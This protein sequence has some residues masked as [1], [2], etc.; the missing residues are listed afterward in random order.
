LVKL[1]GKKLKIK[2]HP[3]IKEYIKEMLKVPHNAQKTS[4]TCGPASVMSVL[5]YFNKEI[6]SEAQAAQ[7]I[8]T[9]V[10]QGS[11][12]GQLAKYMRSHGCHVRISHNTSFAQICAAVKAK[13][14]VIVLF[15]RS[16]K[17]DTWK[18]GHWAVVVGCTKTHIVLSDS[19]VLKKRS[20]LLYDTFEKRWYDYNGKKK[21]YRVALFVRVP[22]P[23]K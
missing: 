7:D 5:Q 23:K 20:R 8:G 14:P 15:Q 18:D 22:Q 6:E 9:T 19:A 2:Y 12:S 1:F 21:S 4:Y 16:K 10:S 11:R 3:I 13:R 17:K